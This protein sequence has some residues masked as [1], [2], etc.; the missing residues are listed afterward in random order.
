MCAECSKI[1]DQPIIIRIIHAATGPGWNVYACPDCA[2]HYL[3]ADE[4]RQLWVEHMAA[5]R[6]CTADGCEIGTALR[7]VFEQ[8]RS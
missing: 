7:R 5:C 2:P 4:A 1:T 8:P 6:V 3:T